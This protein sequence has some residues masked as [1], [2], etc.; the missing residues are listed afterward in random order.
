MVINEFRI[1][2]GHYCVPFLFNLIC[3]RFC[4]SA[5]VI[6]LTFL[7]FYFKYCTDLSLEPRSGHS[8]RFVAVIVHSMFF[9]QCI[10]VCIKSNMM[11]IC[12]IP[13]QNLLLI[14]SLNLASCVMN[15]RC[16]CK[17]L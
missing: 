14:C 10:D 15:I 9:I 8:Q 1:N 16:A 6:S 13:M 11:Y 12:S 7:S 5:V 17:I 3:F 4:F 2:I